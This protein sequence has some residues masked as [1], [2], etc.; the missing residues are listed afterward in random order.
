MK[1]TT[2][3]AGLLAVSA[4]TLAGMNSAD[5]QQSVQSA[6]SAGQHDLYAGTATVDLAQNS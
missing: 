3:F 2:S 1:P 5:A 6:R 4:L